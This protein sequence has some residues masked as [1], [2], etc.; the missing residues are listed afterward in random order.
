MFFVSNKIKVF[1]SLAAI[2]VLVACSGPA[3]DKKTK[4][5]KEVYLVPVETIELITQD[6][7][8]TYRTT[9]VLEARAE[10]KVI[11]KVKLIKYTS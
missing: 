9:A 4:D 7:S 11:K 1:T 8:N 6:I 3:E 5:E 10:S 2:A